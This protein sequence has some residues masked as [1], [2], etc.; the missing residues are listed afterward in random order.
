[1]TE[2]IDPK[3]SV[4]T[5]APST[6]HIQLVGDNHSQQPHNTEPMATPA[7]KTRLKSEVEA[8]SP[9][10]GPF[11]TFHTTREA[12]TIPIPRPAIITTKGIGCGTEE[13]RAT[14]RQEP[15]VVIEIA[16]TG[17]GNT[18]AYLVPIPSKLLG[19]AILGRLMGK[20]KKARYGAS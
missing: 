15:V 17:S 12:P 3:Y 2:G 8:H 20:A 11:Q 19:K 16:Y 5:P 6:L 18:A 9:G 10:T 13:Q 4:T 7:P 1:H 14:L